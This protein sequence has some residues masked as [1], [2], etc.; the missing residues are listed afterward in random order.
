MFA[1]DVGAAIKLDEAERLI[2]HETQREFIKHRR[3]APKHFQYHPL[4]LRLTQSAT[5][6]QLGPYQ[7]ADHVD[8]VCYDFGAVSLSYRIPL[9]GDLASLLPLSE[10]LYDNQALLEDSRKRV[11]TLVESLHAALVRPIVTRMVE[12]YA[13]FHIEQMT[14]SGGGGAE[15]LVNANAHTIAQI[16]RCERGRLS[17]QE[18]ADALT[19]RVSFGP[20]DAVIIDWNAALI[21]D[22]DA[23]D[24]RAV[25]EYANVQLL[26]MRY[27]D[28]E[29]DDALDEAY[30]L[31]S[32][33]SWKRNFMGISQAD[34]RR[35]ARLQADGALLFESVS[36][37][38]KLIGDQYLAR[39][40]RFAS[41]RFRLSE[42]DQGISRKLQ[43]LESIYQK[44]SDRQASFRMETL[45]WIIILLIGLS[46]LL[47]LLP[48]LSGH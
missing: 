1:Y 11:E 27:L 21:I 17:D 32:K 15:Q 35:I 39:T 25:L 5:P 48:G 18:V 36:N 2:A 26:E 7:T 30:A 40:Y 28:R 42:W 12:D 20:D 33:Q 43:A 6:V 22:P 14:T 10:I 37:T 44:L 31:L 47:S 29:F 19:C 16:L 24:V 34:M 3:R 23:D 45:E 46:I 38:L 8:I 13:L 41:Q 9:S 4:P